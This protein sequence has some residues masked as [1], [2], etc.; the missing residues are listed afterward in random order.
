MPISFRPFLA[1]LFV[2]YASSRAVRGDTFNSWQ[3][4]PIP[5]TMPNSNVWASTSS[6]AVDPTDSLTIYAGNERGI[7]KSVDGGVS[8]AFVFSDQSGTIFLTVGTITDLSI[9]EDDPSTV[10]AATSRGNVFRTRDGG[11]HWVPVLVADGGISAL[12]ESRSAGSIYVCSSSALTGGVR[13][14]QR[15]ADHGTTWTEMPDLADK[16]VQAFAVQA[17]DP[18]VVWA[19]VSGAPS[20]AAVYRSQDGGATWS[21]RGSGL[22]ATILTSLAIDSN[23]PNTLYAS[24][25]DAGVFKTSDGGESW[26][27]VNA[28]LTTSQISKVVTGPPGTPVVYASTQQD[29]IFRTEDGGARWVESGAQS[30]RV[31]TIAFD[32]SRPT[33]YAGIIGG[34]LRT[35]WAPT[36]PCATDAETLCLL[37][38]RFRVQLAWR[39]SAASGA[40]K[41]I[42]ITGESGYFWFFDEANVELV[43]KVLDGRAVNRHFWVFYGALS[44]VEYDLTVADTSTGA[45]RSYHNFPGDLSSVADTSAFPEDPG[46]AAAAPSLPYASARPALADA[47]APGAYALCLNQGRFRVDVFFTRTPLGPSAPAPAVPM[48]GDTGYFWFFD[49]GNVELVVKVL[50]GRTVNGHFWVFYGA[51]SNVEYR[52]TVTDTETGEQRTYLNERGNLASVADTSAF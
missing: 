43:V 23:D 26:T 15:S 9:D 34:L 38:G 51:L 6:V 17:S 45:I 46:S 29:G 37:D 33:L 10:F 47:C 13:T 5:A 3:S 36:V 2:A 19:A 31:N 22:A 21:A 7:Y 14:S 35:N 49:E 27:P 1:S 28:G 11:A 4:L 20:G 44:S 40:A 52:I 42:P 18:Q 16:N 48:T 39:T 25:S 41:G 8:W 30:V 12:S 50:D 32:P 24:S